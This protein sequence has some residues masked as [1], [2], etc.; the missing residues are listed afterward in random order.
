MVVSI[1][2]NILYNITQCY[3]GATFCCW[4][5]TYPSLSSCNICLIGTIKHYISHDLIFILLQ[6]FI[7]LINLIFK[8]WGV[9]WSINSSNSFS[10]HLYKQKTQNK[11]NPCNNLAIGINQWHLIVCRYWWVSWCLQK[12]FF[13]QFVFLDVCLPNL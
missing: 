1:I 11:L 6:V 3:I 12:E 2:T 10:D 9:L 4:F 8:T 7:Q 5:K 13:D